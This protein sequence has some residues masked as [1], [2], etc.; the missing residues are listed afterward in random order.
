VTLEALQ[1][2]HLIDTAFRGGL[3]VAL[4][5]AFPAFSDVYRLWERESG[6][7]AR[8]TQIPFEYPPVSAFFYEPLSWLPSSRWAV[9]LNGIIMIGAAVAITRTLTKGHNLTETSPDIKMWVASP[10]LLLFLPIN[11][12][13]F[14]A[15]IAV[16]GVAALYHDRSALA[17]FWH[18]IGTA[19]K[20]FPG[21]VVF[22]IMPL[23]NGWR[24]R[25][26]FLLWGLIALVVPYLTYA[27]VEPD[28]WL[29]HLEFASD[30][31]DIQSTIWGI[32]DRVYDAVGANLSNGTINVLSSLSLAAALLLITWWAARTRPSFAEVAAVVVI[33]MLTFNKVFKPQYIL[34]ALPF[35]AWIR[36][37]R[38][39]VRIA[40]SAAVLQFAVIYLALPGIIYPI[41]TAIRVVSLGLVASDI[42]RPGSNRSHGRTS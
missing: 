37:D 34:W 38:L 1:R 10:A 40:E 35:L 19:F 41:H 16:L 28:Q 2:R 5:L 36:A 24:R 7:G 12:D 39:K 13:V 18:G 30:R 9:T 14:V 3:S 4:F 20:V 29:F 22:P 25:S 8:W 26:I 17:G 15:L 32:L 31:G 27:F 21:A 6:N 42:L 23:I 33:A 11:W